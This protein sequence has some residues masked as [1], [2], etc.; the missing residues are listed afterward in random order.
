MDVPSTDPAYHNNAE[1]YAA[2]AAEYAAEAQSAISDGN[3]M[4]TDKDH[5]NTRYIMGFYTQNKHLCMDLTE[6]TE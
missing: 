4:L 6:F 3:F 5:S 2:Q 1:Y